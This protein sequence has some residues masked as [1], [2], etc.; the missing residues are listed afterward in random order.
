MERKRKQEI[1]QIKVGEINIIKI[2]VQIVIM[3]R[4]SRQIRG[5]KKQ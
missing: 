2:I 3:L 4:H 1:M 5:Y